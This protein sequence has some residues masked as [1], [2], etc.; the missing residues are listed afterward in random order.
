[1]LVII[2]GTM[3]QHRTFSTG[4]SNH[5]QLSIMQITTA[6]HQISQKF[7]DDDELMVQFFHAHQHENSPSRKRFLILIML[8]DNIDF[9]DHHIFKSYVFVKYFVPVCERKNWLQGCCGGVCWLLNNLCCVCFP[10][11][12]RYGRSVRQPDDTELC[13]ESDEL[14]YET[15]LPTPREA[16]WRRLRYWLPVVSQTKITWQHNMLLSAMQIILRSGITQIITQ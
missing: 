3:P 4:I 9:R 15:P 16:F 10:Q 11:R 2:P 6:E 12:W 7:I 13:I 1:M 8:D 14:T 5:L